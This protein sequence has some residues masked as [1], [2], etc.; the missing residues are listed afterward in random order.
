M[1]QLMCAGA[2]WHTFFHTPHYDALTLKV[3][4]PSAAAEAVCASPVRQQLLLALFGA[5][6]TVRLA[7]RALAAERSAADARAAAR[8]SDEA[9]RSAAAQASE[10]CTSAAREVKNATAAR[11]TAEREAREADLR[12]CAGRGGERAGHGRH[13]L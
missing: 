7:R 3:P 6:A 2:S 4:V 13:D 11:K 10:A 1:L 12:P 9:N 5:G 8:A